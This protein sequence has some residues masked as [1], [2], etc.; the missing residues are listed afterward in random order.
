[1]SSGKTEMTLDTGP[2]RAIGRAAAKTTE[3]I[4]IR[5][6]DIARET[7]RLRMIAADM[8]G[9]GICRSVSASV[10]AIQDYR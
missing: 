5:M 2:L 7:S 4:R 8:T 1:M 6:L 10:P 3:P 9:Y